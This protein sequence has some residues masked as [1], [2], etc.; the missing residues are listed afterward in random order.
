MSLKKQYEWSDKIL[1]NISKSSPILTFLITIEFTWISQLPISAHFF[2]H[3]CG[4][5]IPSAYFKDMMIHIT[6][7]A[8]LKPKPKHKFQPSSEGPLL[9]NTYVDLKSEIANEI[10]KIVVMNISNNKTFCHLWPFSYHANNLRENS[11]VW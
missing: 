4:K 8:K 1:A 3:I 5:E 7:K 2:K 11:W 9:K 10:W 6:N